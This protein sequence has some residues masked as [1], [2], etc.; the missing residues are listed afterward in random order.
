MRVQDIMSREVEA[1]A[2]S[3]EASAAW[4]RMKRK[5]IHHLV[6]LEDGRLVGVISDRD[7]GSS[8]AR[9]FRDGKQVADLMTEH[10]IAVTPES[11]VRQAANRLRGHSIGCLPVLKEGKLKGILTVSDLLEVL[12]RGVERPIEHSTPWTLKD[13]GPRKRIRA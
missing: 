8:R 4:E 7:L 10:V 5:G 2:P 13:R 3:T 12:G 11:T 1:V 6:V 9:T